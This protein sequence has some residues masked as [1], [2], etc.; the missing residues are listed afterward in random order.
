[1]TIR[2]GPAGA[3]LVFGRGVVATT[4]G[5]ALTEDSAARVRA[6]AAHVARFGAPSRIVFTGGWAGASQGAPQPPEGSREGDLMLAAARRDGLADLAPLHAETGSRST[7]ENLLNVLAEGL[8]GDAPFTPARPLG[9]VTHAWHLPR[10]RYLAGKVL[11]LRGDAL[12]DVP[13]AGGHPQSERLLHLGS[14]LCFLGASGDTTLR[15]RE[16]LA[17]AALRFVRPRTGRPAAGY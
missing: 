10:V 12:L 1:M 9:L 8:L 11:R 6:A 16:R 15:R 13:A 7:L 5:F 2:R 17:V 3:L 14:R 4:G